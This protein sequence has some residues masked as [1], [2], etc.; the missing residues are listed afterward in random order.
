MYVY[1]QA[2]FYLSHLLGMDE[3]LSL[4]YVHT[5]NIFLDGGICKLGGFENALL[6]Y[7]TKKY[8]L[9]EDCLANLDVLMFGEFLFHIIGIIITGIS[10]LKYFI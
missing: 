7:R 5:G 2:M 8:T 3:L 1:V 4:G 10:R 6:G 9:Y